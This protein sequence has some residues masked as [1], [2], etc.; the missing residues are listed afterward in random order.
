MSRWRISSSMMGSPGF[1]PSTKAHVLMNASHS[2][3]LGALGENARV[4]TLGN[5]REDDL[6]VI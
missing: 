4:T 6:V 5:S 3:G 1:F 2:S